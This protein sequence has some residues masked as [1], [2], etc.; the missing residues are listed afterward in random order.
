MEKRTGQLTSDCGRRGRSG[1]WFA[2]DTEG[3]REGHEW[4]VEGGLHTRKNRG[5]DVRCII[6]PDLLNQHEHV[7]A[8]QW[9]KLNKHSGHSGV[10]ICIYQ[11]G[12]RGP[13]HYLVPT[14]VQNNQ[15]SQEPCSEYTATAE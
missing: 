2:G 6:I 9:Q 1:D 15:W 5:R 7:T 14:L 13:L 11:S 12:C 10:W 8:E 3:G 4:L